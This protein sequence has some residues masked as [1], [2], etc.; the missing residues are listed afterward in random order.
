MYVE[1]K[2]RM[3]KSKSQKNQQIYVWTKVG[4]VQNCVKQ[5]CIG[6]P[7]PA[8]DYGLLYFTDKARILKVGKKVG[9]T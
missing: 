4:D 9:Y 2:Q 1:Y 6:R 8:H 3:D 7:V 5:M